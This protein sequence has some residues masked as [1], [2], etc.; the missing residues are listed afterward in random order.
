[1]TGAATTPYARVAAPARV[2]PHLKASPRATSAKEAAM[3]AG[4]QAAG[5]DVI[6]LMD[7]DLRHPPE[8][9]PRCSRAGVAGR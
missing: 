8:L 3:A 1:M 4:L 2:T 7:G 6:V 5:G 9:I